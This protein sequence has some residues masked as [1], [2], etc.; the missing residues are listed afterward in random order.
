MQANILLGNDTASGDPVVFQPG[1]QGNPH[2]LVVGLPGMGKT[3][4]VKKFC[5]QLA[6][7]V[8]WPFVI[9]FHGDLSSQLPRSLGGEVLILNAAA[10]L[11][12]NP[13]EPG[14]VW[15]EQQNGWI[16]HYYQIAEIFGNLYPS[17]GE[18]QIGDLRDILRACY[19]AKGFDANAKE[20]VS[21]TLYDFWSELQTRSG[22]QR[23]LRKIATRLQSIFDLRLFNEKATNSF[24]SLVSRPTVVDLHG[25]GNQENERVAASF[26][27]Q[28][29]YRGMFAKMGAE[30][31]TTAIV[32]D[33][34]HR[35]AS[36]ELIARMMQESRK[37]GIMF[38]LSSQRVDDFQKGVLDSA[39]SQ[40]CLRVN[41]PDAK[42][43][44]QYLA[45]NEGDRAEIQTKLMRLP[46]FQALFHTE[47][48][49][50]PTRVQLVES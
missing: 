33:E 10:G 47:G 15:R 34:A 22:T 35:L 26:L 44:S 45:S 28:Q 48:L 27:L 2:M 24:S 36:L 31:L 21:P 5:E 39:G 32:L 12:F 9:D 37:Y 1:I 6:K 19:V 11:D 42:R 49:R 13:L 50:H 20:A 29:M 4:A 8:I 14:S 18:V 23:D 40:L 30:R 43:L 25:L 17:F 38:I 7:S 46:R 41:H 3:T 16:Q